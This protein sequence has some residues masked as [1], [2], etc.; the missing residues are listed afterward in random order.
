MGAIRSAALVPRI[1]VPTWAFISG[2]AKTVQGNRLLSW[3]TRVGIGRECLRKR[4]VGGPHY[5]REWSAAMEPRDSGCFRTAHG[6]ETPGSTAKKNYADRLGPDAARRSLSRSDG[7]A[8]TGHLRS[9]RP[10]AAVSTLK[11]F[12]TESDQLD[13]RFHETD[14]IGC[15]HRLLVNPY[16][17]A[18]S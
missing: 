8:A 10:K 15:H 11:R 14:H 13:D 2:F 9:A 5:G 16:F 12:V 4:R 3:S 17:A 18:T 1:T 6:F 7:D